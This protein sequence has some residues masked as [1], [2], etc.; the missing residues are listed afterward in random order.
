MMISTSENEKRYWLAAWI[1]FLLSI[2]FHLYLYSGIGLGDDHNETATLINFADNGRLD[3]RDFAHYR[4][5]NVL[6]RGGLFML[7]NPN[8]WA[9]IA[10]IFVTALLLQIV[11][12][13]FAN[14]LF[15]SRGALF[16]AILIA[17]T[18]YEAL[19]STMNVP[20]YFHGLF[21]VLCAWCIYR[22]I[23]RESSL[24]MVA[25]SSAFMLGMLN[26][27]SILLM[28]PVIGLFCLATYRKFRPWAV[29]WGSLGVLIAALCVFDRYYSGEYFRWFYF[30][31]GGAGADVTDVIWFV[32]GVYPRYL[33]LQNDHGGFL[34]G[35]TGWLTL[36]GGLVSALAIAR[37]QAGKTEYFLAAAFFLYLGLF[38]FMPHRMTLERYY[39]HPRIFRYLAQ[40]T[41]VFYL[42]AGYALT[43]LSAAKS[44]AGRGASSLVIF[45]V[46]SFGVYQSFVV[47]YPSRD[48][49][50]DG[51]ALIQYIKQHP[52]P[53]N[54]L[55]NT[56]Y[57]RIHWISG[58][59]HP[60]AARL[61][62]RY[63]GVA[64]DSKEKKIEF[65]QSIREGIV[66]TGGS[67]AVWYSGIELILN[68]STL[69]FEVPKNWELLF[70]IP[71]QEEQWRVEPLR[72]WSVQPTAS[73]SHLE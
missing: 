41:P 10:P 11:T 50:Q 26:R 57:W 18:P 24:W 54:S 22:G 37:R 58:Q 38:E 25:A 20:D 69:D 19:A 3:M 68:L 12:I 14:D 9:L 16:T 23:E 73:D 40:V 28:V 30:N 21:G 70:E 56:D 17:V 67:T 7:F 60:K 13:I 43:R 49:N 65:L 5:V 31:A 27:L 39:S 35:L 59:M 72:V 2:P 64:P 42:C 15:G 1:V 52:F 4:I 71:G 8:E 32:W 55:I 63:N 44:I 29:F 6:L 34:F 48:G 51:R 47:T 66:I 45:A 61:H 46:V 33:L 62:W 53:E 36:A